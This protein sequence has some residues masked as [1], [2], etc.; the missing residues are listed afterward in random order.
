MR[1]GAHGARQ[2]VSGAWRKG[3]CICS[4]VSSVFVAMQLATNV[5][6][7]ATRG[8]SRVS[9]ALQAEECLIGDDA[10]A[11]AATQL[12]ALKSTEHAGHAE[13]EHAEQVKQIE[14]AKEPWELVGWCN[15]PT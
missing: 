5:A 13:D 1:L 15:K 12:R 9:T 2:G 8:D 10:C 14:I 6:E 3:S 4:I 7:S 11:L